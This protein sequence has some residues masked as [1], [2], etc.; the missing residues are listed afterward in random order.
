MPR[1]PRSQKEINQIK[2]HILNEALILVVKD[3]YENLTMRKLAS[4]LGIAAK[5]IYNYFSSKEEIY[6]QI[7]MDGFSKLYEVLEVESQNA[8]TPLQ[9]LHRASHAWVNFGIENPNYYD[10]MFTFFTP[11]ARDF[12]GTELEPEAQIELAN[13]FKVRDYLLSVIEEVSSAYSVFTNGDQTKRLLQWITAMHGI[14]SLHNSTILSY[15]D[16]NPTD[17]IEDV[18]HLHLYGIIGVKLSEQLHDI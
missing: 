15:L 14:V 16:D 7:R 3:G 18:V 13:A 4:R 11:K 10:I 8:P 17:A 1:K 6:I 5:T 2:L 9:R 12:F